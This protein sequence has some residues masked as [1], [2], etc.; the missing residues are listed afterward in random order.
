MRCVSQGMTKAGQNRTQLTADLR[1]SMQFEDA[2]QSIKTTME[3]FI[4]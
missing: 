4:N 2:Q 3:F 1:Q